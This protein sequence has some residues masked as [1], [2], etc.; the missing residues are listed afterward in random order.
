MVLSYLIPK[1]HFI[2]ASY[3]L[4]EIVKLLYLRNNKTSKNQ[5]EKTI[6]LFTAGISL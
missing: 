4:I 2:L 3:I 6:N 1:L 5:N